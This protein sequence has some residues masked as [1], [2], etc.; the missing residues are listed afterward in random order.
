[1]YLSVID[2]MKEISKGIEDFN[3]T[4]NQIDL[5]NTSSIYKAAF[6]KCR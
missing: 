2:T 6:N 3:N 4:I 5:I 1:M